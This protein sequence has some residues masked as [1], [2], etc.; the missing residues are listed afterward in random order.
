MP[1]AKKER[2]GEEGGGE[3]NTAAASLMAPICNFKIFSARCQ[4]SSPPPMILGWKEGEEEAGVL[5]W[6]RAHTAKVTVSAAHSFFSSVCPTHLLFS[7]GAVVV[8][9]VRP[10]PVCCA[11]PALLFPIIPHEWRNFFFPLSSPGA[12]LGI[13]V[14]L[15]MHLGS[16]LTKKETGGVGCA[17]GWLDQG[18]LVR[19]F[20]DD[21][22]FLTCWGKGEEEEE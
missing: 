7:G 16:P 21:I 6:R 15:F 8:V 20:G 5:L 10:P 22:W 14:S 9:V 12:T 2:T 1:R 18:F 11:I 4:I 13:A 19:G 17:L 3:P